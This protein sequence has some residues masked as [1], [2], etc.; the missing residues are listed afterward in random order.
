MPVLPPPTD[1]VEPHTVLILYTCRY[2]LVYH[3]HHQTK[4]N[5]ENKQV[6]FHGELTIAVVTMSFLFAAAKCIS[7]CSRWL[8][9]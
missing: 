6:L 8:S 9:T 3:L 4:P 2:L 1:A 5:S 7:S